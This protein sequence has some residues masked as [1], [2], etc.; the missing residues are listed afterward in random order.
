MR[1]SILE[2]TTAR[3]L[4]A[5]TTQTFALAPIPSFSTD[6]IARYLPGFIEVSCL[7]PRKQVH[8]SCR[9]LPTCRDG[10]SSCQR[11]A[12]RPRS[13]R[14]PCPCPRASNRRRTCRSSRENPASR[15]AQAA[16]PADFPCCCSC[17]RSLAGA[18]PRRRRRSRC[19]GGGARKA[20]KI[21]Q[22]FRAPAAGRASTGPAARRGGA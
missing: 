20:S 18:A 12:R 15:R 19:C 17:L 21:S 8:L 1:A 11:G 3:F 2:P 7:V 4:G 6:R 9:C 22:N 14:Y 10:Q 13:R 16:P 5:K